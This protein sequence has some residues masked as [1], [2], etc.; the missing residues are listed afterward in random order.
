MRITRAAT[1]R[2]WFRLSGDCHAICV[3]ELCDP[4]RALA[5]GIRKRELTARP[6]P[7]PCAGICASPHIRRPRAAAHPIGLAGWCGPTP[8]DG[9]ARFPS[10]AKTLLESGGAYFRSLGI[11]S[12]GVARGQTTIG[13]DRPVVRWRCFD[14]AQG[15]TQVVMHRIKLG[16]LDRFGWRQMPTC[17]R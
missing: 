2:A 14:G 3:L 17:R 7:P 8:P 9:A 6:A 11:P 13:I 12:T 5:A 4:A 1:G 16:P 10:Q 15:T